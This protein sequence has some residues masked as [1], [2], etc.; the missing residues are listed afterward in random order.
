V[1]RA[2]QRIE[3]ILRTHVPLPLPPEQDREIENIL[4][5]ARAHYGAR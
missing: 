2:Q 4:K 5:K 1:E 3:E